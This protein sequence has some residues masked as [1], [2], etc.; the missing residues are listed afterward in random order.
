MLHF[1]RRNLWLNFGLAIAL[2]GLI[3]GYFLYNLE[4]ANRSGMPKIIRV[5]PHEGFRDIGML[6]KNEG[7]IRSAKSFNLYSVLIGQA[8]SLKSGV[9]LLSPASTTPEIINELLGA[10]NRI[11]SVTLNEGLTLL[12]IEKKLSDV[13]ALEDGEL[14][15]Q[16]AS[17][18]VL[19]FPYLG[20][21]TN[22][23]GFLFPDTYQ[24]FTPSDPK[25][26]VRKLLSNFEKK[27]LPLFGKL[28]TAKI[29]E[30]LIIASII[31][32]EVPLDNDRRIVSGIIEKRLAFGMPLQVDATI[33]YIKCDLL[34]SCD[35]VRR[36]TRSDFDLKSD[37]NTY[38]HLGLTPAPISNPGLSS[39]MATLKPR[40]SNYLYYLSDPIR[41]TTIFS[42]TLDEQNENRFKY[43]NIY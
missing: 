35:L 38:L 10:G 30:K 25:V 26:I 29:K 32:K 12:E 8:Q 42:T 1:L 27:A 5:V 9:Y 23:E 16:K 15:S 7:I 11:V 22:L 19:E 33:I 14:R 18:F 24:F 13:G 28:N 34:M 36:L 2:G 40:Q 20:D 3:L 37:Y 31:E 39:I 4:P 41:K 17:D 6:L 21:A 43:L